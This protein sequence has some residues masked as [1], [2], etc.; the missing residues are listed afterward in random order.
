MANDKMKKSLY[1]EM[2]RSDIHQFVNR[3]SCNMLEDM[4]A[5]ARERE[6]DLKMERKR[7][8]DSVSGMEGSGKKPKI[9]SR[10]KGQQGRGRCGKC[11]RLHEG[12]CRAGS[13]GYFKCGRTGHVSRDCTATSTTI[14]TALYDMICFQCN[15]RSHKRSRCLSLAAVG[16]VTALTPATLRITDGRQCRAEAPVMKSRAFQLTTKEARAT[17][18][19]FIGSFLVN[20]ISAMV[21]FDSGAT[22]SFVSLALSKRFSRAPRE[23]D[24]PFDVEIADDRTVRVTT[25]HRGCTLLLFD[26]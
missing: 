12:T 4:I 11:G 19:V 7:K 18:D 8:L 23:L 2:L 1:H 17:P 10:G 24:C 20:G 14:T 9:D 3:S 13:S 21:L 15:Q 16:K 26:E 5:R 22:R 6:I 25:V